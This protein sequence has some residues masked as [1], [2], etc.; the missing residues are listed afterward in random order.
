MGNSGW[1][2]VGRFFQLKFSAEF[3][4]QDISA[5]SGPV[6]GTDFVVFGTFLGT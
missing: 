3:G 1:G 6:T 4:P 5:E 2:D